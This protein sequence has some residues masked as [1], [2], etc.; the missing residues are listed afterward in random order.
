MVP[1][2]RPTETF[3]IIMPKM[4]PATCGRVRLNP[5]L[6]P[7]VVSIMLF[8]PGVMEVTSANKVMAIMISMDIIGTSYYI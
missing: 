2:P 8:G 4:I 7:E 3:N 1:K 6:A 5:K